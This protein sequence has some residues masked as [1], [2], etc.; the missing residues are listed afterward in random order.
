MA[1]KPKS[2]KPKSAK[3]KS[4]ALA[5]TAAAD[6]SCSD[7]WYVTGYYTPGEDQFSGTLVRITVKGQGD[8]QFPSDFLSSVRMEGWGLTRH[9]WFLGWQTGSGWISGAAALN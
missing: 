4:P 6:M 9:G 7:G 5:A 2:A 1:T 8:D 3:P